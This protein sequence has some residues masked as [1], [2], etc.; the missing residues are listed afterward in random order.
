MQDCYERYRLSDYSDPSDAILHSIIYE[1]NY[2]VHP[3]SHSYYEIFLV[4]SGGIYHEVNGEFQDV[5][6]NSIIFIRPHDLHKYYQKERTSCGLIRLWFSSQIFDYLKNFL[7]C[8]SGLEKLLAERLPPVLSITGTDMQSFLDRFE[9]IFSLAPQEE[10]TRISSLK[11]ILLEISLLFLGLIEK[12]KDDK[13]LPPWIDELCR[14]MSL[15]DNFTQGIDRLFELSHTSREHLS[16][17]FK[18]CLGITPTEYIKGLRLNYAANQLANTNRK[19]VDICFDSGF[20]N[21]SYFYECFTA[22]YGLPPNSYRASKLNHTGL[23]MM[24]T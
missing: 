4:F 13:A 2:K 11:F 12:N 5:S 6:C 14:K 15:K 21:M 22:C 1:I 10:S 18:K 20:G 9:A 23:T 16:R 8:N 24:S 3:H 19:I 17:T 7:G